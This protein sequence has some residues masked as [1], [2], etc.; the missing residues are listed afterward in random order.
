[1]FLCFLKNALCV[2][3]FGPETGYPGWH[4]ND[5]PQY[6]DANFGIVAILNK[7]ITASI[8]I[9]SNPLFSNHTII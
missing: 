4:F 5:F 3:Y 2:I 9:L 8:L 6:H 7:D 1:M